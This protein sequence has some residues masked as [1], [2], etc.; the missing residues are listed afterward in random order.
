[1]VGNGPYCVKGVLSISASFH[2]AHWLK[3]NLFF[4]RIN[5]HNAKKHAVFVPVHLEVLTRVANGLTDLVLWD[6]VDAHGGNGGEHHTDGEQ[7]EELTGDGVARVLQGQ[8]QTLPY[9]TTA[10]FL[11]QLYVSDSGRG[12]W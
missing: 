7:A 4:C 8:P 6:T 3:K 5:L 10:H 11:K 12:R 9:P 2:I 1:M